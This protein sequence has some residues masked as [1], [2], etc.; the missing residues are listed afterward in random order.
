MLLRG[1]GHMRRTG[2][3]DWYPSKDEAIEVRDRLVMYLRRRGISGVLVGCRPSLHGF[4][5]YVTAR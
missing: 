3:V 2:F 5:V 1:E 4:A